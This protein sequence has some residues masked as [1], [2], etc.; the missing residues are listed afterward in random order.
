M[1][2]STALPPLLAFGAIAKTHVPA[3]RLMDG[4]LAKRQ[5]LEGKIC[6]YGGRYSD[7]RVFNRSR[8][9][10]KNEWWALDNDSG[11][12]ATIAPKGPKGL[13][14][15]DAM[16]SVNV[17]AQGLAFSIGGFVNNWTDSRVKRWNIT[18]GRSFALK[19]ML[20]YNTRKHEVKN[21]TISTL[22]A[23]WGGVVE[24]V[25][26]GKK[27]VLVLIGGFESEKAIIGTSGNKLKDIKII[28]L[29]DIHAK[30]WHTQI[31]QGSI[32]NNRAF[33]CASVAS[34]P[35]NSSHNI[36]VH[37]GTD[38]GS[39]SYSDTYVLSLPSFEWIEAD[40]GR[41][42]QSRMRHD[43]HMTTRHKMLVIGGRGQDQAIPTRSSR[44]NG[45]CDKYAVINVFDTNTMSWQD[46]WDPNDGSTN[47]KLS[48]VITT[49]IG[50]NENGGA[51]VR[52]PSIG[53]GND[54]VKKLFEDGTPPD[55]T[56]GSKAKPT[57]TQG[58]DGDRGVNHAVRG[59]VGTVEL[60]SMV[61][62]AA[63]IVA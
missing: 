2:L 49:V 27:G 24:Y 1:R 52:K 35:D 60:I 58:A 62:I 57:T 16:A 26:I 5:L 48:K 23:Q 13:L 42:T 38:G 7:N 41:S 37:G 61:V 55:G 3:V 39:L 20:I 11:D 33:A 30:K 53:W 50:G 31:A 46:S 63:A 10:G 51:T 14:R 22:P 25:P 8:S 18:D 17:P 28:H 59:K 36:F 40:P 9:V 15:A 19:S 32:P 34:A 6:R 21:V 29:Y 44:K 45:V 12:W 43:C 54:A 4:G 47:F 56:R